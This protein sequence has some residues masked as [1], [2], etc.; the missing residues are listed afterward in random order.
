[1]PAGIVREVRAVQSVNTVLST[2]FVRPVGSMI[3][4]N[5]VLP[6]N[7]LVVNDATE[8]GITI[9]LRSHPKKALIPILKSPEGRDTEVNALQPI[10][11]DC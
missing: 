1:M 11:A 3:D 4:D 5:A 10:N 6:L 8:L 2:I 7:V 9:D